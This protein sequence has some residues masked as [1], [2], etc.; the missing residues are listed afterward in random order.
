MPEISII[1]PVYNSEKYLEQ[2]LQSIINQTFNDIEVICINDGSTDASLDIINRLAALD[3]RIRVINKENSGY[4]SSLNLGISL[5]KG[6][7]IGIVEA[8]DFIKKNMYE[9]LINLAW[10]ND[11]DVVK[12]NWYSYFSLFRGGGASFYRKNNKIRH[13]KSK[14]LTNSKADSSLL[15]ITPSVW[16]A[17]YKKDFLQHYNIKFLETPGA[18]YQDV[19]F[20]FKVF[21]LASKVILTDEAYVM[22]RQDN[23]NSSVKRL[24]KVYCIC[25]EYEELDEF[26]NLYPDLKEC[27]LEIKNINQFNSY[28]WNII[29]IDDTFKKDFTAK[30]SDCFKEKFDAGELRAQFFKRVSKKIFMELINNQ[31]NFCKTIKKEILKDKLKDIRKNIISFKINKYGIDVVILGKQ[32]I[33]I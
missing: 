30:F 21:A 33:G 23:N 1:V 4:G 17:I 32:I 19:S 11:A 16:S 24:D 9:D 25:D 3:N 31:E 10:Q 6:K 18:S 26:L 28:M 22:Y 15:R 8:D 5:A 7:Y 14:K 13:C 12:S 2:C 29:R 20:S 27:F